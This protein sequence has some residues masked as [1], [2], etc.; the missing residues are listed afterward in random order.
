MTPDRPA[1]ASATDRSDRFDAVPWLGELARWLP[2]A[3]V[4]LA[5]GLAWLANWNAA[6][7]GGAPTVAGTVT[8]VAMLAAWVWYAV[9]SVRPGRA[10]LKL[11][12]A[13]WGFA[14]M[15]LVILGPVLR[16]QAQAGGVLNPWADPLLVVFHA[17]AVPLYGLAGLWRVERQWL[18][19]AALA[20]TSYLLVVISA[21]VA[22]R[23]QSAE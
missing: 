8:S 6:V 1:D 12:T 7:K 14:I 5:H 20:V 3:M 4:V 22:K 10:G 19:L 15:G 23:R 9:A 18:V 2:G 11:A 16:L 21:T 13:Y 17:L